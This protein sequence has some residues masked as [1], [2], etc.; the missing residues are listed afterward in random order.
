MF[1]FLKSPFG[2][3]DKETSTQVASIK[4][5]EGTSVNKTRLKIS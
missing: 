4:A 2:A 5:T 1:D 3:K